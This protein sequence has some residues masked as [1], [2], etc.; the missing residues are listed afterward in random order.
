M[1]SVK[2]L[3]MASML[4]PPMA[5]S[6]NFSDTTATLRPASFS[7]SSHRPAK[8]G[9]SSSMACSSA[10]LAPDTAAVMVVVGSPYFSMV[11]LPTSC[12]SSMRA[13]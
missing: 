1:V 8:M 6:T 11:P 13:T 3:P 2:D 9:V 4:E 7:S 5:C 10:A 12:V